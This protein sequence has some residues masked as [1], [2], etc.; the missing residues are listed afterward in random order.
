[1]VKSILK[2]ASLARLD[3]AVIALFIPFSPPFLNSLLPSA[4]LLLLLLL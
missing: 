2:L 4:L 1:M 3:L